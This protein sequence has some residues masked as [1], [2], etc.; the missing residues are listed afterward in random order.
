MRLNFVFSVLV[1]ILISS[2]CKA[3]WYAPTMSINPLDIYYFRQTDSLGNSVDTQSVTHNVYKNGKLVLSIKPVL[4]DPSKNVVTDTFI[5]DDQGRQILDI[6]KTTNFDPAFYDSSKNVTIYTPNGI[7][8][9]VT[10]KLY[11]KSWNTVKRDVTYTTLDKL[12]EYDSSYNSN[13]GT[14]ALAAT[15]TVKYKFNSDQQITYAEYERYQYTNGAQQLLGKSFI[16][17]YYDS[18]KR[19]T[20][21]TDLE[22]D[23]NLDSSSFQRDS[24]IY[25][26]NGRLSAEF[27]T[28][29]NGTAYIITYDQNG[30]ATQYLFKTPSTDYKSWDT[31]YRVLEVYDSNSHLV[32]VKIQRW[33][34]PSQTWQD[35]NRIDYK[36]DRKWNISECL[37]RSLHNGKF[38][39]G[40]KYIT[41]YDLTAG[42]ADVTG[43]GLSN[44]LK[45]FPVPASDNIFLQIQ[46]PE[47]QFEINVYALSGQKVY[48]QAY[49]SNGSIFTTNISIAPLSK[50]AYVLQLTTEKGISI[51]KFIKE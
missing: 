17:N 37:R 1:L 43:T 45:V 20:I 51:Q 4:K 23:K 13:S 25:D 31:S 41:D 10:S 16:Y 47:K 21:S 44:Y 24:F 26:S 8:N 29:K 48:S 49:N 46:N 3:Q 36:F 40:S 7:I 27:T 38:I 18:N 12:S 33:I 15:Q 5:Y 19:K 50:G 42:M 22:L 35:G 28:G 34:K 11:Q 2:Y 6:Q 14:Y 39:S 32:A 30:N 9:M